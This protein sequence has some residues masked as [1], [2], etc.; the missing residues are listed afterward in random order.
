[1]LE[2]KPVRLTHEDQIGSC[3]VCE[4]EHANLWSVYRREPLENG[5]RVA[6]CI[7]DHCT[8]ALAYRRAWFISDT[9]LEYTLAKHEPNHPS[10][11]KFCEETVDQWREL[12]G[13]GWHF[14]RVGYTPYK[15]T[16]DMFA[17][18]SKKCLSVFTGG[19]LASRN[20]LGHGAFVYH[21]PGFPVKYPWSVNEC[22]RA[23]H[24]I[25]GHYASGAS[26]ETFDG[27]LEAYRE[28]A[29]KYSAEALPALYSETVGQLCVYAYTGKFV[30]IQENKIIEVRL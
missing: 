24:D 17:D 26:F 16:A 15:T 14:D 5:V 30:E 9:A 27:E 21:Y 2:V 10:Y 1:M 11:Q 13:K 3:E 28:H 18:C 6:T 7:S 22:F 29:Q 8:E 19:S 4:P 12:L 23:V 25:N 20:P